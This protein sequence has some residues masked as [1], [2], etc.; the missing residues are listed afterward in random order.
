[1]EPNEPA[2]PEAEEDGNNQTGIGTKADQTRTSKVE[3]PPT[4]EK[5]KK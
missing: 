2:K 4:P 5:P 1:V 3:L